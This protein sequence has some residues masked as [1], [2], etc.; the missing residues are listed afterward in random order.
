MNRPRCYAS[1][2]LSPEQ[3]GVLDVCTRLTHGGRR[4]FC[5]DGRTMAL[6]FGHCNKNT[7]YRIVHQLEQQ[8]WLVRS[9]GGIKNTATGQYSSTTYRVLS[10]AEWAKR[11][12]C[13]GLPVPESGQ[14]QSRFKQ[15]PVPESGHSSV[16]TSVLEPFVKENK[17]V[18]LKNVRHDIA[19]FEGK[20]LQ[21][22]SSGDPERA[23]IPPPYFIKLRASLEEWLG[24]REGRRDYGALARLW[25]TIPG[26]D[27]ER[28]ERLTAAIEPAKEYTLSVGGGIE[29]LWFAINMALEDRESSLW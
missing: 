9:G 16:S 7:I 23:V 8:G 26:T 27:D 15:E 14:V 11:H 5:L 25:S 3:W 10:H 1:Q 29:T 17:D 20:E 13:A 12:G 21:G 4:P 18:E 28:Y 6:R 24:D 2:H 19:F 22:E